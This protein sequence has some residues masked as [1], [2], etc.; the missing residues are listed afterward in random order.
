M[1]KLMKAAW[2][3]VSCALCILYSVLAPAIAEAGTTNLK[4]IDVNQRLS[5][6]NNFSKPDISSEP[7]IF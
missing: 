1:K 4:T 6:I 5:F 2:G 7:I 3:H